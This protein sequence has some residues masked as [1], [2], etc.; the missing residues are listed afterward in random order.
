LNLLKQLFK[1]FSAIS[2][3]KEERALASRYPEASIVFVKWK[4][5]KHN[6]AVEL[7]GKLSIIIV[8]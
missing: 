2:I 3:S 8:H 6:N 7:Q 4:Q 5:I 1:K